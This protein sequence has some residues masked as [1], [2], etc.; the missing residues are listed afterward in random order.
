MDNF[1]F[2]VTLCV[3]LA[4]SY[5]LLAGFVSDLVMVRSSVDHEQYAV[6]NLTDKEKAADMLAQLKVKLE[7]FIALLQEK[8]EKKQNKHAMELM[9]LARRRFKAILAENQPGHKFTSYTVNKGEKVF[10]CIR[11]RDESD[12]LIDENTLFYVALHEL[13]HVIT[14]SV[15]HQSDFWSNFR[16][17]LHNAIKYKYLVYKPYHKVPQ[18]Y[19]GTLIK[20][21]PYKL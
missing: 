20:N 13:A 14:H 18:K 5:Q 8:A 1:V 15:G 12:R 9:F 17:L 19:C 21:T 4:C 16:F 3:L 11:E 7:S 10:M 2:F 6:L